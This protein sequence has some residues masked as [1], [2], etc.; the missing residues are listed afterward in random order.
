MWDNTLFQLLLLFMI[1]TLIYI[2]HSKIENDVPVK[3]P[4]KAPDV[5]IK[6]TVRFE[7]ED[8]EAFNSI[9]QGVVPEKPKKIVGNVSNISQPIYEP[10][11]SEDILYTNNEVPDFSKYRGEEGVSFS[12]YPDNCNDQR[13]IGEIHDEFLSRDIKREMDDVKVDG[14]YAPGQYEIGMVGDMGYSDFP[15]Y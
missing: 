10:A 1:F 7:D 15:T 12:E 2:I 11:P 4:V 6:R 5:P 13:T 9:P 3:A 8:E 14:I